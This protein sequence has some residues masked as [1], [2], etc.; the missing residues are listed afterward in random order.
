M[1]VEYTRISESDIDDVVALASATF[2]ESTEAGAF[3]FALT[4]KEARPNYPGWVARDSGELVGYTFG[5]PLPSNDGTY[6]SG[7]TFEVRQLAT[8]P[9]YRRQG[10][11]LTLLTRLVLDARRKD[12]RHIVAKITAESV[13]FYRASGWEVT[14]DRQ[15]LV[16]I[17]RAVDAR[18]PEKK[19]PR[20]T[21]TNLM[22]VET[23][24]GYPHAA[25]MAEDDGMTFV[26]EYGEEEPTQAIVDAF[27]SQTVPAWLTGGV[28]HA[29]REQ[30]R[31]ARSAAR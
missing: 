11:G 24:T 8:L 6:L 29:V 16:W 12:F 19:R 10:I 18:I 26:T 3:R 13:P 2:A 4:N 21:A 28:R 1:A 31:S 27:D 7:T 22:R 23:E 15:G 9:S 25:R 14:E 30:L 5:Q 17:E 20:R